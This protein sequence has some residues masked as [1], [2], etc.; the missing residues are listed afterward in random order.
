MHL[1]ECRR[2][3]L[4]PQIRAKSVQDAIAALNVEF[5]R[6]LNRAGSAGFKLPLQK[7]FDGQFVQFSVA[8][9]LED[10]DFVH[11]AAPGIYGQAINASAFGAVDYESNRILG[12][13]LF[14]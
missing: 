6:H 11:Q 4:P 3:R 8:S 1:P 13:D 14:D 10:F 9:A 5:H 12:F 7:S 2:G